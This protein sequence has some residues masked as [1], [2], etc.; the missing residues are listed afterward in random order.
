MGQEA[1]LAGRRAL[2]LFELNALPAA[3]GVG[4]PHEVLSLAWL[5]DTVARQH[6]V[7]HAAGAPAT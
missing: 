6:D 2:G 3:K 1:E 7:D 4:A 5:L